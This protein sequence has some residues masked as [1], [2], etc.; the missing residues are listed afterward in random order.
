MKECKAMIIFGDDAGD[1]D[2]TFHCQLEDGHEGLHQETGD[3]GYGGIEMPYTLI[4]VGHETILR[5]LEDKVAIK[6]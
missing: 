3:M 1:N 5:M 4:W 2:T 6:A